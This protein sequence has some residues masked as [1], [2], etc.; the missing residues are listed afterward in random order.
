MTGFDNCRGGLICDAD[1][2]VE[3]GRGTCQP[4]CSLADATAP[5]PAGT[6]CVEHYRFFSNSDDDTPVAGYCSATC[7]PLSGTRDADGAAA[8]GVGE[9]GLQVVGDPGEQ[10]AAVLAVEVRV[11]PAHLLLDGLE[12]DLGAE[13]EAPDRPAAGAQAGARGPVAEH[14]AGDVRAVPAVHVGRAVVAA[15]VGDVGGPARRDREAHDRGDAS[16]EV[17]VH[18]RSAARVEP[19]VGDRDPLAGAGEAAAP[20]S[21]AA[22]LRTRSRSASV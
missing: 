18:G 5:C 14:R 2:T 3:Q 1:P 6:A 11:P 21:R 10:V 7:D 12:D 4:I 8:V 15:R 22:S 20:S 19:R 17:L 16:P 9:E 13:R